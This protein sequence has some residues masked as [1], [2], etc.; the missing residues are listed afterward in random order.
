MPY[1]KQEKRTAINPILNKLKGIFYEIGWRG[2]LNYCLY[3]LAKE[4]CY[5]YRDY[6]DF[7]GELEAAKLEIY[8]KLVA[9]YEELK[10]VENGSIE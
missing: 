2:S 9:P 4:H 7:L 3:K 1:I 6:A 8:R 5:C 10:E